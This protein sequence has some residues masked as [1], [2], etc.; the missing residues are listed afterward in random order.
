M[1]RGPAATGVAVVATA[2]APTAGIITIFFA[3]KLT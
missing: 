2:L 3:Q 1:R